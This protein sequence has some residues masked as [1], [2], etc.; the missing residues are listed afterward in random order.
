MNAEPEFQRLVP[1]DDVREGRMVVARLG[2]RQLAALRQHGVVHVF[3]NSC[4]H[5]GSPLN[6]G[7]IEDGTI[8]CRRHNWAFNLSDGVCPQHDLYS[9][10]LYEV[11]ERDG[12]VEVREAEPEIW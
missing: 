10:R 11:R 2:V 12:W 4:P 7:S 6:R 8:R 3:K 9:L 5:A 1:S